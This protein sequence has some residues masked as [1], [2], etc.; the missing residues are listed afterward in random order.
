V[1]ANPDLSN[2]VFNGDELLIGNVELCCQRSNSLLGS[3]QLIL[4]SCTLV[5][6]HVTDSTDLVQ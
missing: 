2:E 3:D 6:V 1:H 4:R 5:R